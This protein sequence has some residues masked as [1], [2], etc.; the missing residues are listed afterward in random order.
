[1]ATAGLLV[2]IFHVVRQKRINSPNTDPSLGFGHVKLLEACPKTH[3]L[4]QLL[5]SVHSGIFSSGSKDTG[6]WAFLKRHTRWQP[7]RSVCRKELPLIGLMTDWIFD[8]IH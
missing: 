5:L 1:M 3:A 2:H 7:Q 6:D 4:V 8:L